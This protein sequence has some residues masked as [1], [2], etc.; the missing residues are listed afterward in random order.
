MIDS[1]TIRNFKGF[2]QLGLTFRRLTVLTGVNSGGKSSIVQAILLL[3]SDRL[4]GGGVALNGPHGLALGEGSDVLYARAEEQEIEITV[5]AAGESG[6]LLLEVPSDRS[7]ALVTLNEVIPDGMRSMRGEE[8]AFVYLSAERWGPRDTQGVAADFEANLS[9]GAQGE[10]TAH[11][12]SQLSRLQVEEE[13]RHPDTVDAGGVITL[14]AQVELWMSTIVCPIRIDARWLAGTSVATL[15]FKS[16][17]LLTE[18]LRP[19]NV[20]FGISHVL[21]IVV[22]GLTVARGGLLIVENPE[23]HLHPA[24]QSSIGRFLACVAAAGAQVVVETHSDHVL[25]GIRRSVGADDTL[26]AEDIAIHYFPGTAKVVTV[27]VDGTGALSEWP[28]GFFDQ[29]E[30]DLAELARA[31][32][33]G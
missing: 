10:Y 31:K 2:E 30:K 20:G 17:D 5:T 18:W 14:G 33:R 24:G 4:P 23:S 3:H 13:R 11:V 28:R 19:G 1:I 9:V 7:A 27:S 29:T 22:A 8:R 6:C 16:P 15:R 21:P 12:M 25:D 26:P 32:R